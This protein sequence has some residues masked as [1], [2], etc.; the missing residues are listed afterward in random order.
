MSSC[1][2]SFA[3]VDSLFA[4]DAQWVT[5]P[6]LTQAD[7]TRERKIL[8]LQEKKEKK[9]KEERG[10]HKEERE[11]AGRGFAEKLFSSGAAAQAVPYVCAA[12]HVISRPL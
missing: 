2:F 1:A 12:L 7:T 8:I 3:S 4:A 10:V 11:S 9:K 5:I 6:A